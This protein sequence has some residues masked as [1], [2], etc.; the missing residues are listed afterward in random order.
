[1]KSLVI[2]ILALSILPFSAS[3][4]DPGKVQIVTSFNQAA[5][6]ISPVHIK[7]IDG[8]EASVQRMGFTLEPGKHS[9]SGSAVINLSHCPAVGSTTRHHAAEPLEAVFEPG[10]VYYVGYD[11]NSADRKDWKIVIWKVE[12]A[13]G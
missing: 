1:M 12:D 4:G 8:K 6:C 5:Q 3:A 2:P 7:R 9:L 10:K 13:K 11:H